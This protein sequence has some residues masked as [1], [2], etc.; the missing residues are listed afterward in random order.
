M[1]V[2][3]QIK[4]DIHTRLEQMSAARLVWEEG[5]MRAATTELYAILEEVYALYA[6]LKTEVSKRRAFAALLTDLDIKAQANTSLA[7]KVIRYGGAH[8]T[9]CDNQP[10]R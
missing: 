6:E 4:H 5:T 7:L 3:S 9:A 2:Q 10:N 8:Q 1:S